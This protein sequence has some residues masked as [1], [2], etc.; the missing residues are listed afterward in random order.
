[1]LSFNSKSDNQDHPSYR[2]K[3]VTM[4]ALKYH[5]PSP[6]II[7]ELAESIPGCNRQ[8]SGG[9]RSHENTQ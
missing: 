9:L 3:S 1:M 5:F 8:A 7:Y 2:I 4:K 6:T